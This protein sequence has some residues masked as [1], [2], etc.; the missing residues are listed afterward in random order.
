M[1]I[2]CDILWSQLMNN[3]FSAPVPRDILLA[4]GKPSGGVYPIPA[5]C[6]DGYDCRHNGQCSRIWIKQDFLLRPSVYSDYWTVTRTDRGFIVKSNHKFGE[7]G[8]AR[9]LERNFV[10]RTLNHSLM[11]KDYNNEPIDFWLAVWV[12]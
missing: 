12:D 1:E 10:W 11:I 6:V 7:Y 4:L 9:K 3:A 8:K 2:K 5:A